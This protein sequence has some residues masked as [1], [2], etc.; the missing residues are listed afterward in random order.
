MVDTFMLSLFSYIN[1]STDNIIRCC[2]HVWFATCWVKYCTEVHFSELIFH[3]VHDK[4]LHMYMV[5]CTFH[6]QIYIK[7][8]L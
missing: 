1:M 5:N 4:Y 8:I 2:F 7:C 6:C 3:F